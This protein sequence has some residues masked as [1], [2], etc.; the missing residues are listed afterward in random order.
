MDKIIISKNGTAW[1]DMVKMNNLSA[2]IYMLAQGTPF[3]YSGEELLREKKDANGNRYDNAYGTDDYINK[4]RWSDLQDKTY[5]Q[6]TDDYYAG[7]VAF[8]KNHAALRCPNGGDAWNYTNYYKIN[9][10][11]IMFYVDGYPNW[12]CSDGI[13][14]IYNASSSTQWV[15]LSDYG[16]PTGTWNACIH[17]DK[18]GIKSLAITLYE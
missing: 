12:E 14:I 8:R 15:N 9:D 2:A 17:G 1:Y 16:I 4:I 5:A 13:V 3:I 10:H 11:L 18:A 6:M 7:L